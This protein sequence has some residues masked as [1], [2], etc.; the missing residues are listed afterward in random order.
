VD[1]NAGRGGKKVVTQNRKSV[2]PGRKR[3]WDGLER[4]IN[5]KR[6]ATRCKI[7][8]QKGRK[9]CFGVYQGKD[10]SCAGM[11][12]RREETG[13]ILYRGGLDKNFGKRRR[14]RGSG[15]YNGTKRGATG[16]R[17]GQTS[18]SADAEGSS[19][20]VEREGK[21]HLGSVS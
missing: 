21:S 11:N 18:R 5:A 10:Q 1:K 20:L 14:K 16:S 6:G 12:G 9:G 2:R 19:N 17:K 13:L 3:G 8:I 4:M 7:A 15:Y